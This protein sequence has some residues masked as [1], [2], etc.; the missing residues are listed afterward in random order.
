MNVRLEPDGDVILEFEVEGFRRLMFRG[1]VERWAGDSIVAQLTSSG[2]DRDTRGGATIYVDRGQVSHID[3]GG[4]VNGDP[5]RLDWYSHQDD[6]RGFWNAVAQAAVAAM[7]TGSQGSTFNYHGDGRGR[8]V[9]G[10]REMHVHDV[11]VR[12]ERDGDVFLDFEAEGFRQLRFRGRV[13]RYSPDSVVAQLTSTGDDRETRGGATIYVD[14]AG[15]VQQIDMGGRIEGRD[16]RLNWY[17]H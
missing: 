12:L 15:Q 14:R 10:N 17:S 7:W 13:E 9:R 16:F 11:N 5:F 4:R 6:K 2:R 1:T 3:M 8:F